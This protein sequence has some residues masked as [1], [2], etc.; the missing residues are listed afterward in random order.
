MVNQLCIAGLLQGLSEG[1]E[2]G[3][4]AHL[5]MELVLK[6]I[7]QGAAQ[8]WQ[9]DNR[10]PTMV[11]DR[12]DFGFAVDWMRKDLGLLPGRGA[13]HGLLAAGGGAGRPSSTRTYRRW[14]AGAGTHPR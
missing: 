14:A 11:Q 3:R 13:A 7:G 10:G 2:F 1:I 6:V 9:M 5:D 8:S 12:F 4:R